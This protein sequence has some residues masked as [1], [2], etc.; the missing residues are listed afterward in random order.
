MTARDY[1]LDL[2]RSTNPLAGFASR[3]PLCSSA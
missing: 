1:M 3:G 2:V